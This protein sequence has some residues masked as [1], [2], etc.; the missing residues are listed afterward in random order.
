MRRPFSPFF[1]LRFFLIFVSGISLLKNFEDFFLKF[2]LFF[3]GGKSEQVWIP[4]SCQEETGP[5]LRKPTPRKIL[6]LNPLT[7]IYVQAVPSFAI[8][9]DAVWILDSPNYLS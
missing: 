9:C 2:F 6:Y 4:R 1:F 5:Y 7:H 3:W 8:D